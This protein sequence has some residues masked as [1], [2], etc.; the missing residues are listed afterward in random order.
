[1]QPRRC[2]H[3]HHPRPAPAAS[4]AMGR[5]G[6]AQTTAG[7]VPWGFRNAAIL[8]IAA[9]PLSIAVMLVAAGA[10]TAGKVPTSVESHRAEP[11]PDRTG[12]NPFDPLDRI[13][14]DALEGNIDASVELTERLLIRF[15]RVGD[16]NDLYEAFQWITRDWSAPPFM[17]ADIL[18]T[19]LL[20]HCGHKVL[21]WHWLCVSGE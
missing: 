13:R 1:M 4:H 18:Q 5:A 9:V 11:A 14:V 10:L 21:Q 17:Q 3:E 6:L 7:T 16:A 12:K 8:T 20:R 19:A 2:V 15:E